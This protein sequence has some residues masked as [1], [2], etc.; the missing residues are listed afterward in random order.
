M[1][2]GIMRITHAVTIALTLSTAAVGAAQDALA[3]RALIQ[4]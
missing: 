4:Q 2:K 3:I 1:R